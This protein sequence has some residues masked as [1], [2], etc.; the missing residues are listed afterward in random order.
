MAPSPRELSPQVTEG[1]P[2]PPLTRLRRFKGGLRGDSSFCLPL[3]GKAISSRRVGTTTCPHSWLPPR[4][5]CHEVT[6]GVPLSATRT[7]PYPLPPS[8]RQ[9]RADTSLTEGG[10]GR[11]FPLIPPK[12]PLKTSV[13]GGRTPTAPTGHLP[14]G[15]R[16]ELPPAAEFHRAATT[17]NEGVTLIT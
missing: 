4:G 15:G 6:E 3:W 2:P 14:H 12:S 13:K 9:S 5:S 17:L 8:A 11:V 10:E 1:V 16:Q 7:P